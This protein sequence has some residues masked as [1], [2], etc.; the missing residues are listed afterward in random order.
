M[1]AAVIDVDNDGDLDW[2]VS[3]VWDPRATPPT[4]RNWGLT[5]NRLYQNNDGIFTDISDKAGVRQGYWGWGSCFADFNNDGWPDIFHANGFG[6]SEK[7]KQHLLHK[8]NNS[9]QSTN[10]KKFDDAPIIT[11]QLFNNI[12]PFNHTTSRL[13]IS[14][15]DGTFTDQSSSWGIT[16]TEQGRAVICFDYDRD[17]DVDIFV[18]NNQSSPILYNNNAQSLAS[19]NFINIRL[20]GLNKNSQAV[21]AKVY[22]T[23][24]GITQLQEVKAGG[25]F[26]S[27]SPSELHF[28]LADATTIERIEV[29]WPQPN[30]IKHRLENIT[31]NQFI[32]IV[33]PNE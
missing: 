19:T 9:D 27:G 17:G 32:T 21:G 23:A 24:D 18:S 25:S 29:I 8:A 16:D 7:I 11:D 33:Q 22:V 12:A 4:D 13:Y 20:K 30:Y 3:S 15:Q 26:I 2:F 31:T 28:G 14:N 10:V 5:G 6:F 1:G